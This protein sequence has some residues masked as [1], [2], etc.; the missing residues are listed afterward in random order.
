VLDLSAVTAFDASG[1]A[2]L[3]RSVRLIW[4]TGRS[5]R[6]VDPR[7]HLDTMPSLTAIHRLVPV[8]VPGATP[9]GRAA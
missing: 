7:P 2:V 6:I 1:L 3:V 4:R 5:V 9:G 8:A